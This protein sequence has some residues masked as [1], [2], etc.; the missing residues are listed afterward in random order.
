MG[1][2]SIYRA[3]DEFHALTI[4]DLLLQSGIGAMIRSEE[5]PMSGG[6]TILRRPW[7]E[8]LV[9]EADV[10]KAIELIAGFEGTLGELG[11]A[12]E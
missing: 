9:E 8:V 6:F 1:L 2:V 3:S 12:D 7:G 10:N 11:E 4:R 5:I